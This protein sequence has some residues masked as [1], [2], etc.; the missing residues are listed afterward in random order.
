MC[1][2][3]EGRRAHSHLPQGY[4][5][6]GPR[7]YGGDGAGGQ[8]HQCAVQANQHGAAADQ[9]EVPLVRGQWEYG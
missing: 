6:G 3:G 1:F 9:A 7:G 5:R 8:P 4:L 2:P